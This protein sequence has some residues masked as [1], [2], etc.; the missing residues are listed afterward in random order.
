MLPAPVKS[1]LHVTLVFDPNFAKT[2]SLTGLYIRFQST[3]ISS[4]NGWHLLLQK[5][6]H[7]V[8]DF[9]LFK[10]KPVSP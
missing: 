1:A 8:T 10:T 2:D 5:L 4:Q 9:L 7:V 3:R 6:Q